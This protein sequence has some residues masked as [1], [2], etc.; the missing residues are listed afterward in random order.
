MPKKF[1]VV[2]LAHPFSDIYTEDGSNLDL[3]EDGPEFFLPVFDS[4]QKAKA[5]AEGKPV[6]EFEGFVESESDPKL[7]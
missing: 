2:M 3:P 6:V 4:E 1:W 5:W 7:N